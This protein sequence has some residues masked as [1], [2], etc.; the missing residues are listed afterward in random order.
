M[1]ATYTL[2]L[3]NTYIF[4]L[5]SKCIACK[6]LDMRKKTQKLIASNNNM[7]KQL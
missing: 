4:T 3:R 1:H 7:N 5:N 2:S 6:N